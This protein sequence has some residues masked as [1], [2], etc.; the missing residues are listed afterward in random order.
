MN[1]IPA[2][3]NPFAKKALESLAERDGSCPRCGCLHREPEDCMAY[4][5]K[6]WTR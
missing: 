2:W 5:E 6:R 3:L 4:K 1:I